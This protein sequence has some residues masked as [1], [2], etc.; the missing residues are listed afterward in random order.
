[1][2]TSA[3][4]LLHLRGQAAASNSTRGSE[5]STKSPPFPVPVTAN[6]PDCSPDAPAPVAQRP[7]IASQMWDLEGHFPHTS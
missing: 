1:M 2:S 7:S 3:E 4:Y 6:S 5:S